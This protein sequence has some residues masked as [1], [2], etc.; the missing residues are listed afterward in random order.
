MSKQQIFAYI[1]LLEVCWNF[2][3]L[4]P[5]VIAHCVWN[6]SILAYYTYSETCCTCLPFILFTCFPIAWYP[7]K[8]T[9]N[10]SDRVLLLF[11]SRYVIHL[12][13]EDFYQNN[14]NV[15]RNRFSWAGDVKET[16]S[17]TTV[18]RSSKIIRKDGNET[19]T[20][21]TVVLQKH[22][23]LVSNEVMSISNLY[24]LI[25]S[26]QFNPSIRK[27]YTNVGYK[28]LVCETKHMPTNNKLTYK[29]AIINIILV[30]SECKDNF[31]TR[32]KDVIAILA[33]NA[34]AI[35]ETQKPV[36]FYDEPYS[37]PGNTTFYKN[38]ILTTRSWKALA[39]KFLGFIKRMNWNRV[40]V[41]SDDSIKSVAFEEELRKV[42]E[43]GGVSY[44]V[45][46]VR[47]SNRHYN[48][49]KVIFHLNYL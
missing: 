37:V 28:I 1:V 31:E 13:V 3:S 7:D 44:I 43:E 20:T 5:K 32:N 12:H 8:K 36:I 16:V 39:E 2:S 10:S 27:P 29:D 6:K 22:V 47:E 25:L 26:F 49:S 45:M 40:A 30:F 41:L 4:R 14:Y 34:N 11:R 17:N 48:F 38:S 15:I 33:P 23:K 42:F 18:C 21:D 24:D 9:S 46:T 35:E 19:C